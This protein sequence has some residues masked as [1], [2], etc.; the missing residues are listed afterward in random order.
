M[1]TAY[2]LLLQYSLFHITHDALEHYNFHK[3]EVKI[4]P[5]KKLFENVLLWTL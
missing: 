5:I 4:I 1:M 3:V 2:V